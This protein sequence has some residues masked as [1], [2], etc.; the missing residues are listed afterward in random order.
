M[1]RG[2]RH[3]LFHD[4]SM[5]TW[6]FAPPQRCPPVPNN[7]VFRHHRAFGWQQVR[8]AAGRRAAINHD[9]NTG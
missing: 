9:T 3:G 8:N 2:G 4:T 1:R 6:I 5:K 7:R